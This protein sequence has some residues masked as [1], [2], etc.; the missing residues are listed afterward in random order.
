MH[1]KDRA[2]TVYLK[3][4]QIYMIELFCQKKLTAFSLSYLCKKAP[5]LMSQ[6]VLNTFYIYELHINLVLDFILDMRLEHFPAQQSKQSTKCTV[7]VTNS[8]FRV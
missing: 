2:T 4:F 6:T 1:E 8:S 5:S 7:Q 3:P